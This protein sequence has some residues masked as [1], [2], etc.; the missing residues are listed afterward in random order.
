MNPVPSITPEESVLP[1]PLL[2]V[3][4]EPLAQMRLRGVLLSLGYTEEALTFA[5]TIARA[6]ALLAECPFAMV[7]VDV[8]L[9]DGNGIG[10]I[11][12]IHQHDQAL[13]VLVI[14]T[15]NTERVIVEALQAGATGYV[16]KEREDVEGA[17]SIR[18][19]LRGGA[20]ID[21]FVARR[22]LELIAERV[23]DSPAAPAVQPPQDLL[24]PRETEIIQLVSRG[25]T[26]R[27]IAG[28]LS[29]SRFTVE[30]HIRNVY[31]KLAVRSRTQ[32]V[33]EAHALGFLS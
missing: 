27:E 20:P 18:S 19:A 17:L 14:S 1:S 10:L 12:R 26:N 8:G 31:K 29:L 33:Y 4:D 15:W 2:V 7:L 25:L 9:P 21:P 13:P 5:D 32:A 3:E 11:R 24:S 16:L 6:T 30:C 22:I 28:V 23:P